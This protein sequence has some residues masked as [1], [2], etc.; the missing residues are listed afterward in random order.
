MKKKLFQSFHVLKIVNSPQFGEDEL[1][2][3]YVGELISVSP[4]SEQIIEKS[5]LFIYS[6]KL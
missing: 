1:F 2:Y 5:F 3:I 6:I 4:K